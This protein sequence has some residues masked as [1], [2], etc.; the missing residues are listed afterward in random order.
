MNLDAPVTA[1]PIVPAMHSQV[2]SEGSVPATHSQVHSTGSV[3]AA[4]SQVH[5]AGSVPTLH[6]QVHST[7]SVAATHSQVRAG[8][9]VPAFPFQVHTAGA[10]STVPTQIPPQV[11]ARHRASSRCASEGCACR[12]TRNRDY[13]ECAS[14]TIG[15]PS[16]QYCKAS[17]S[18][19]VCN[20][21]RS[22]NGVASAK[23]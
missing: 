11:F 22:P 12:G 6:S 18:R 21:V 16:A 20:P 4:H 3:P 14:D 9:S 2:H 10:V 15:E 7:G 13:G 1:Q 23:P 19:V 8:G 17:R 5:F